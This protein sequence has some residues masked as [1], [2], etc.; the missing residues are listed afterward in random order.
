MKDKFYVKKR[1]WLNPIGHWN[2]GAIS[3]TV[4]RDS[5]SVGCDL[6]IWDC[7]RK[8]SLDLCVTDDQ[9]AKQVSKKLNILIDSLT[10]IRECIGKAYQDKLD[11]DNTDKGD[12]SIEEYTGY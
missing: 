7:S 12:A 2:T 10:E 4:T 5:Y 9:S 1:K 3:Y 6:S 11:H 8:V